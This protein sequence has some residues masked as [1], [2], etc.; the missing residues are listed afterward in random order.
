[1]SGGVLVMCLSDKTCALCSA[2]IRVNTEHPS[3]RVIMELFQRFP[4]HTSESLAFHFFSSANFK[5]IKL[6]YILP[7]T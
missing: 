7:T 3:Q 5:K 4:T 6:A 2:L 1:M